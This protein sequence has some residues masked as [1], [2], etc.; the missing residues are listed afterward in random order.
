[1]IPSKIFFG[2]H[3]IFD[4]PLFPP[5]YV[6]SKVLTR[7]NSQGIQY[8]LVSNIDQLVGRTTPRPKTLQVT[9]I[10]KRALGS[11]RLIPGSRL[12]LG[13]QHLF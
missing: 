11:A 2:G 9:R 13:N 1:M 10:G 3:M 4:E 12:V 7:V 8:F 5:I 6:E